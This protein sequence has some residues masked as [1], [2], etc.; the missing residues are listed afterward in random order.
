MSGDGQLTLPLQNWTIAAGAGGAFGTADHPS[1]AQGTQEGRISGW[2]AGWGRA[3]PL[4]LFPAVR[5]DAY[6]RESGGA[7]TAISPRLGASAAMT[8]AITLKASAGLAFRPPTFNDR[9]W[10][11]A[12]E[13]AP[14]GD[15]GLDPE[16]GWTVDAGVRAR[17]GRALTELTAF[18]TGTR[19][20]IV[21]L[22]SESGLYTPRNL[23]R[24]VA[25]G[26]ELTL[27][28][29]PARWG[30]ARAGGGASYTLTDARDR[31]DPESVAFDRPLRYVARHAV[32]GRAFVER[33]HARL[34]I[35]VDVQA[36]LLGARPTRADGGGDLPAHV[37]ADVRLSVSRLI[38]TASLE[39][40]LAVENVGDTRYSVLEG[41]P[42]PPRH[43]SLT[44]R[45]T[46]R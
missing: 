21:W 16:R 20:Q 9:Y 5:G 11:Y 15:P 13:A 14:S 7:L 44:L 28:L 32:A 40:V 26:L 4:N 34:G 42:M 39:A 46:I 6:I 1:L 22:P 37:V 18:R 27:D 24:T 12:G 38:G 17:H 31:S 23:T 30:P 25:R 36:R 8:P 43:A 35:R 41:Y 33:T 3:G 10:H 29:E 19:D 45:L 2:A